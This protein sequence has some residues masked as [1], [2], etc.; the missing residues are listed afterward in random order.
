MARETN[1]TF[2]RALKK[3]EQIVHEMEDGQLPLEKAIGKFE[4]GIRLT[5]LCT[6]KLDATEQRIQQLMD[7]NESSQ[8]SEGD[9]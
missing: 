7:E 8:A 1:M 6:E 5:R 3:L 4:E 2:E 9:Q